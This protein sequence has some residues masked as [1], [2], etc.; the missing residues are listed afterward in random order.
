MKKKILIIGFGGTIAMVHDGEGVLKPAKNIEEILKIVPSL[1]EMADVNFIELSNRDSTN[2]FPSHWKELI[3]KIAEFHDNFDGIIITHGTDTMAYT[4]TAVSLALG[5]GLKIPIIF[6]GSQ[7]PLIDVGT[8]AKF[9]LENSMKSI[10]KAVDESIAEVM[11]VFNDKVLRANRTIKTSEA[12]FSAF[13]SPAFPSLGT[14]TAIGVE[15]SPSVFKKDSAISFVPKAEFCSDILAIDLVP[16]L[17]ANIL[18]NIL[19]SGLCKS[20]LFRSLG[21]GNVPSEGEFS[22]I[23]FIDKAVNKFKIPVLVSTK[24]IGGSTI[25]DI[26][27]PGKLALNA[28]A[29]SARD[30]TDV[31]AQVKLMWALA[32]GYSTKD[33]VQKIIQTNIVGEIS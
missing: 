11:I 23:P 20:F 4:S 24:F 15:F 6:T 5:R 32:Q 7:L 19:Q 16:G 27:E 17:Q 2:I 12:K 9:N 30:M 31:A 14:I 3:L 21:A 28:G 33:E 25:M 26:Y 18:E 13:D 8:D 29:I 22:L 1:K 10:I